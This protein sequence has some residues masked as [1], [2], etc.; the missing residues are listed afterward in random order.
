MT[1][2][3]AYGSWTSPISAAD[4]ARV[5]VSVT[6]PAV[7]GDEVWWQESRP[8]EGGRV[9]IMAAAGPA[10]EPR[11]L[12][13]A[14]WNARTRVH[15][16]GGRSYLPVPSAAAG[17][18]DLVFANFA[19]QRLYRLP[20]TAPAGAGPAEAVPMPLTPAGA[21]FRFADMALSPDGREIWC[22]RETVR[23]DDGQPPAGF[24][25]GGG[26]QVNRAIVAVP[27]DGSAADPGAADPG[28]ARDGAAGPAIRTLVSG[29]QF[30]AFPTPS[31][32]GSRLAW[33]NWDHPR[34]PWDGT[35]LRVGNAAGGVTVAES[36]LVM[37]GP[38]E[39]VLAPRWRTDDRL[40]AISDASG[41]WNL[42]EVPA[43][44]GGTPR[45]LHPAEEEFAGPLWQLGGRPFELL[46]DGRLA[47]LHGLGELRLAV[48]DPDTGALDDLDLPGYRTVEA[49]LAVCGDSI[50]A[51]AAGPRTPWSVLRVQAAAA[52]GPGGRLEVIKKQPVAA[53]DP[54]YL[55]D[56]RPVRLSVGR[57][58]SVV[59]ALVY[60]PANPG[61][62]APAGELPP[63][64][65]HVHG[66]P[67]SNSMPALS[68]EKAF[69]TSR[70]IGIID[71][72]YGGSTGYGR[73]YRDRLRGEWGV[74]D[75]ADAM[76]GALALAAAGVADRA[77]LGIRGGSAGGWTALA[78]VTS[79]PALT[80]IGEAV[81]AAA[82]SYYGVAD[83]R[84][85]SLDTHDFESRYLDGLVG[86]LPEA[87]A[88]Y[89]ERAPVGHVTP[90]TCPVLLLQGLD[91]PIVPPAQSAAIAAELAAYRIPHAYLA[92]E[93]ESHGFRKA[94]TVIACLEAELAFYGEVF[95]FT[96][97]GV[98]PLKLS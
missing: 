44:G 1:E 88:L 63:F 97:P 22:V 70:G 20:A 60:A 3:A 19:D 71:V 36:A 85:L 91:D 48:L 8:A 75:V 27:L 17:Q 67:T 78:A 55:P 37:G 57:N 16:Y 82:T 80:G 11:E 28:A 23:P 32:D 47:V 69:F 6:F 79:G 41:W 90:L 40:Y 34:M 64:I 81:F 84:P 30:F 74:V 59:H 83:L 87:E 10:V 14:P 4:V 9:T 5:A 2:I 56:A 93:G 66:G 73:A 61:A 38:A 15:E 58:G 62:A 25:V 12:L 49:E 7:A 96:P 50:A 21:G 65:V 45:P 43:V 42:Y 52:A 77:R 54:A 26:A 72:N 39:S 92:F 31:P 46:A 35:E 86:P 29:A 13:L 24:H 53:S 51:V 95:G 98:A 68:M 18:F 33:I 76:N 89:A 94:E